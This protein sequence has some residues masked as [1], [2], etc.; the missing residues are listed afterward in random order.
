MQMEANLFAATKIT[1]ANSFASE[2][3]FQSMIRIN[4]AEIGEFFRLLAEASLNAEIAVEDWGRLN[5]GLTETPAYPRDGA[6]PPAIFG[7]GNQAGNEATPRSR[8]FSDSGTPS[9]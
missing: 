4:D 7:G 1:E 3:P 2:T 5:G 9:K 6:D 8:I